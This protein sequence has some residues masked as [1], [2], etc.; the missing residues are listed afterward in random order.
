LTAM[1]PLNSFVSARVSRM[2]SSVNPLL[3]AAARDDTR[4]SSLEAAV[5]L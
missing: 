3:R 1:K 4:F 2:M 5:S